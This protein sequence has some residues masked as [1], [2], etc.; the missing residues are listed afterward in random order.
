MMLNLEC[1]TSLSVFENQVGNLHHFLLATT[2]EMLSTGNCN[3]NV[4]SQRMFFSPI[5]FS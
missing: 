2:C 3:L 4:Q 1:Q 5:V